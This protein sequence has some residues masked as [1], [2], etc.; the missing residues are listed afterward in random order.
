MGQKAMTNGEET[1]KR[2]SSVSNMLTTGAKS[3]RRVRML[4]FHSPEQRGL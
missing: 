1:W 4:S 2:S 3:A